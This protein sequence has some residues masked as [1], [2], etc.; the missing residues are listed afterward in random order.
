MTDDIRT[1][2]GITPAGAHQVNANRR[3][4][5]FRHMLDDGFCRLLIACDQINS[6]RP[7]PIELA[8]AHSGA[9]EPGLDGA[10]SRGREDHRHLSVNEAKFIPNGRVLIGSSEEEEGNLTRPS[11]FDEMLCQ[12]LDSK[13]IGNYTLEVTAQ[14]DEQPVGNAHARLLVYEKD[15]ELSNTTA[16]PVLLANLANQTK[17][18]GGKMVVPELL[19]KTIEELVDKTPQF[20][21]EI[22][23]KVT[24]WDK[25]PFFF[26]FIAL[27]CGEW[28]LRKRWQLV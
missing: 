26:L 23:E 15:L 28:Y 5:I 22:S 11:E 12:L 16:D 2:L 21:E 27:L 14:H 19:A 10:G 18:I 7:C 25:Q 13:P 6:P 8:N 1:R 4:F 24:Y 9:A 3:S 20:D 17:E